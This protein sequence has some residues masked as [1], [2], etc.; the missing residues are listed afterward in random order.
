MS[1]L[2]PIDNLSFNY[3]LSGYQNNKPIILK[4]S[5]T[6]KDLTN[7][8]EALKVFSGFSAATILAQKD[9]VL[10]LERAVPGIS[11]EYS[12]DNKIAIACSV[13]SKLHRA[14]TRNSSLP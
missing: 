4:L 13:M 12:S 14:Y 1:N 11:K 8:A 2:K 3:V 9:K 7:E 10:L 6:A 5:F